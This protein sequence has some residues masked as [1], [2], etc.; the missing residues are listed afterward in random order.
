MKTKSIIT[1][2]QLYAWAGL[3]DSDEYG[4]EDSD[5]GSESVTK[6]LYEEKYDIYQ[7]IKEM[8]QKQDNI[9]LNWKSVWLDTVIRKNMFEVS[10]MLVLKGKKVHTPNSLKKDKI[11]D[12]GQYSDWKAYIKD[13][14]VER[15]L[16]IEQSEYQIS[17][18]KELMEYP[19]IVLLLIGQIF[20]KEDWD[21]IDDTMSEEMYFLIEKILSHLND[22]KIELSKKEINRITRKLGGSLYSEEDQLAYLEGCNKV[23][24]TG[25]K[26]NKIKVSD[27]KEIAKEVF[28]QCKLLKEKNFITETSGR[29]KVKKKNNKMKQLQVSAFFVP[30]LVTM[31]RYYKESPFLL[32]NPIWKNIE[33][34]KFLI[35]IEGDDETKERISENYSELLNYISYDDHAEIFSEDRIYI[36]YRTFLDLMIFNIYK[37]KNYNKKGNLKLEDIHFLQYC[38]VEDLMGFKFVEDISSEIKKQLDCLGV[39]VDEMYLRSNHSELGSLVR[40][41]YECNGLLSRVDLGKQ[42]VKRYFEYYSDNLKPYRIKSRL[43]KSI[44]Q[45]VVKFT[46]LEALFLGEQENIVKQREENDWKTMKE[47]LAIY[48]EEE[49]KIRRQTADMSYGEFS[50]SKD[51]EHIAGRPAEKIKELVEKEEKDCGLLAIESFVVCYTILKE[52]DTN[53]RFRE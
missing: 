32:D 23:S 43:L 37:L 20:P 28:R 29:S 36:R 51:S 46:S 16:G 1:F 17:G 45:N 21:E 24:Q 7:Y 10:N 33:H 22:K 9:Y 42:A 15:A 49:K 34:K 53:V 13:T 48:L 35:D 27:K 30:V 41:I 52:H 44:D 8:Q 14:E 3:Y 26:D 50:E 19:K 4:R 12:S 25:E 6:L 5:E 47:A 39:H 40:N 18:I 11:I 2:E 38:M 31:C